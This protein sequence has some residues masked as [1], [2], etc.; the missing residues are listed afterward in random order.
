M[1]LFTCLI[2][3]YP[4]SQQQ[5]FTNL[6]VVQMPFKPG[7]RSIIRLYLYTDGNIYGISASTVPGSVGKVFRV[8]PGSDRVEEVSTLPGIWV[9]DVFFDSGVPAVFDATFTT[10]YTLT[11]NGKLVS[12]DSK[13]IKKEI[14]QVSGTRPYEP[15]G[16][17]VSRTFFFDSAGNLYTAGKSGYLY[18]Y[19]PSSSKLEQLDVRLPSVRG[20][21]AWATL[22]AAVV[23]ENGLVYGGTYDGYIFVFNPL[24]GELLNLGK[25][26]R[27]QRIQ[28]LA[29]SGEYL[30]GI[31][32]D[33]NG[34]PRSFLL[35]LRTRGFEIGGTIKAGTK[36]VSES[37]GA[38]IQDKNGNIYLGTTGR[39]GNLFVQEK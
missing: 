12:Y 23:T 24:S 5:A 4:A 2:V 14:G 13:G 18:R 10:L 37:I 20:R 15:D 31:G 9:P 30:A 16:Y 3:I 11:R 38:C 17:Q 33:E 6:K 39:L 28:A 7:E 34:F 8:K 27:Q 25:P 22:D 26:L 35:N 29:V 19:S 32:G 21:E 36:L 1:F